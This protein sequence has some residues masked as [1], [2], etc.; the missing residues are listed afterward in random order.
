MHPD[1]LSTLPPEKLA[2][3]LTPAPAA[4]WPSAPEDLAAILRHQLAAPLLPDLVTPPG[5]EPAR[6][7]ALLQHRPAET[8]AAHLAADAPA[9]ELLDA[10]KQ[11]AR[12]ANAA[13]DHP[14]RGDPAT[15]LYYA[16]IAAALLR[17]NARIS[18]LPDPALRDAFTWA[19][20]QPAAQPLHP[21]FRAAHAALPPT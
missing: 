1:D 16:A 9:L 12:H 21:L 5:A 4:A 2:A 3:L 19:L 7:A 6:L 17:C 13:P 8:F 18:Q 15:L 10:I 11:F 20:Q 14:L